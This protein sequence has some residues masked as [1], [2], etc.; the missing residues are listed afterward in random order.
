MGGVALG[1]ASPAAAQIGRPLEFKS[2]VMTQSDI[3][4]GFVPLKRIR[5][6]GMEVFSTPFT[7]QIGYGDGPVNALDRTSPGGRPRLQDN[8]LFLRVNGLDAQTCMECHSVLS[9]LTVPFTFGVGGVGGS[10]SNAIFQPTLIDVN[11]SPS[12]GF[13]AFNGRFINPPFLFGSGGV[14]LV[15]K[16]M[17]ADLQALKVYA[18]SHPGVA[19][20]LI[21]KSVSFG[22]IKFVSGLLDT[23]GVEGIDEDLVVRPFGRKGEFATV[24]AFDVGAL[25]FHFGMQPLEEVGFGIDADGDGVVN[26]ISEGDLSVLS[27]FITNLE[28]PRVF[29]NRVTSPTRSRSRAAVTRFTK[30]KPGLV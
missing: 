25:Q 5:K 18:M 28:R 15:A 19:V 10:N 27:I 20:P 13:A 16:E 21:T 1:F 2:D 8:G 3:A 12:N 24:R 7:A 9:N 4:S 6:R 22:V 17:T 26:E 14:E 29:V 23:S 30:K 11:D